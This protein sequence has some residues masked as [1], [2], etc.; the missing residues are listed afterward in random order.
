M[1]FSVDLEKGK[2]SG[3]FDTTLS[4]GV[5]YR[6]QDSDQ[7]IIGLANGGRAFSVNGDDGNLNYDTGVVSNTPKITSELELNFRH[8]GAF[9]RGSAFYDFESE[10]ARRERTPLNDAAL[11]RVGSRIDLLDAYVWGRFDIGDKPAEIRVGEQ[12]VSWGESTFIQNSIN[13]I[14]PVDVSKLRVPGAELREALL[15]EGL[16]WASFTTSANTS[17]EAFYLYDWGDVEV[18]PPGSY[19]STTDF[20][21][22]GGSTV[23]LGF[24]DSTDIPPFADPTNP[25]R[26]FLGVGRF[27]DEQPDDSGQYGVAFRWLIPAWNDTELGFYFINYHSRLPIINGVTGTLEGAIT[28][29]AIA[30]D[31][32]GNGG[33]ADIIGATI[34]SGGNPAAGVAAAG[35]LVPLGAAQ[36]IAGAT[37]L[38]LPGGVPAAVDAG[39]TVAS[40]FAVDAY[41]RTAGYL[42]SFPED[43]KLYG[44]SFNTQIGTTGLAWQG[45][46]S[47]RTDVPLQVDDVELLFAA[48]SPIN[49][50]FAGRVPGLEEGANQVGDFTGEFETLVPG[51]IEEDVSQFQTTLT[52][53]FGPGIGADQAVLLWEGAVTYADIPDKD[54][55]RLEAPGTYTSGNP[56]H[57]A[58]NPGAGHVGKP[59]EDDSRYPDSTSWGYR[60]AGRL[61][62]NNAIGAIGLS[63]RFS[64]QHDVKGVSPGPG[65]NFIEDRRAFTAGLSATYLNAWSADVSY[66]RFFGAGRHNLVNDRDFIAANIKYSF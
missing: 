34:L 36:A 53:V 61:D 51:F 7:D 16:V 1:A 42:L 39:T 21:G 2:M 41:A 29:S 45:E 35:P 58:D 11:D 54:E 12:V 5:S 52:K 60:L 40:A 32:P 63:P 14:N 27:P 33:A 65:G 38:A 62:F 64:W 3:S 22:D 49:P 13:T 66:T 20:V 8:W 59:A 23:F 55:L 18:D 50:V 19:F 26:P 17:I 57:E 56:Y 4:Y 37:A 10:E 46:V 43:I 44:V 9:I 31:T 24:G 30:D 28:T 47:Y 6:T 15:P 48:L 25:A